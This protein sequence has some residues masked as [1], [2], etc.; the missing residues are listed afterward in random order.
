MIL[1]LHVVDLFLTFESIKINVGKNNDGLLRHGDCIALL[2]HHT[3]GVLACDPFDQESQLSVC[4]AQKPFAR[5]LFQVISIGNNQNSTQENR[6]ICWGEKFQLKSC[7]LSSDDE[8][9]NDNEMYYS[10][11]P[12]FFLGSCLKNERNLSPISFQQQVYLTRDGS[13][14][15][16]HW[17]ANIPALNK[18]V[19]S[20]RLFSKGTPI[21]P[22]EILVLQ[23]CATK[24]Y[25]SSS[26]LYQISTDFGREY[27]VYA[28]TKTG[29]GRVEVLR[30]EFRGS[31]TEKTN[32]KLDVAEALWTVVVPPSIKCVDKGKDDIVLVP[33]I[34]D[35]KSI[36]KKFMYILRERGR[37]SFRSLR[38]HLKFISVQED[39]IVM[40]QNEVKR[41]FHNHDI[42]LSAEDYRY[43][44]QEFGQFQVD[45]KCN[46]PMSM[47]AF[48]DFF[49]HNNDIVLGY[50]NKSDIIHQIYNTIDFENK[51]I[52]D[53]Q[54]ILEVCSKFFESAFKMQYSIMNI[55]S[56]ED[57][58][59]LWCLRDTQFVTKEGK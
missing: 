58:I 5:A 56:T 44:F 29:N 45:G 55:T 16:T 51:G 23:H 34:F 50:E 4:K 10:P 46:Y 42:H 24:C 17:I 28:C 9:S 43:I 19:G 41:V 20:A 27:E 47:L 53:A 14:Y 59:L 18:N 26:I 21:L 37:L 36:C 35:I 54:V 7:I 39:E 32:C 2:H 22:G 11:V 38:C 25:L 3:S 13:K 8:K 33:N 12:G 49:R 40:R 15:D 52:V 48:L 31:K 6:A 30:D 1:I 57:L